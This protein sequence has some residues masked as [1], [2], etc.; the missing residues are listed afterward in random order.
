MPSSGG[1]PAT[2][3]TDPA[4]TIPH[5]FPIRSDSGGRWPQIWADEEDTFDVGWSDQLHDANI[6][7]YTN[8]QTVK[9]ALISS[10]DIAN[11]A[12][13]AA[14]AAQI[15]SEE[16]AQKFGDMDA[17]IAAA[18]AAQEGAEEAE[19]GAEIALAAAI[20]A[21]NLALQYRD[22]AK[23]YRDQA[24]EIAGFD[25]STYLN[26]ATAQAFAEAAQ[27][28]ARDNI[29]AQ[30]VLGV[31][32]RQKVATAA[33]AAGVL[34]LNASQASIWVVPWDQ[35]ITSLVITGWSPGTDQQTLSLWLVAA[36][37]ATYDFGAAF[38]ALNNIV[39][40]L[41]DDVGA[42]NLL[43]FTTRNAGGRV[44]YSFSGFFPA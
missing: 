7:T 24:Q 13:D 27:K 1:V 38:K 21:R 3:Y 17:A 16:I 33:I 37:G 26:T 40:S 31:V 8:V 44:C 36:G 10:A 42:E 39:P 19:G 5:E 22:Q 20:D 9:D 4:L 2:V 12:A 25:P 18:V 41:S 14:I 15:A 35:N 30:P 32:D 34:T 6:A 11:T 43:H 23:E 28:Q 29:G